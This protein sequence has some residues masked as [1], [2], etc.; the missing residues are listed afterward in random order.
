MTYKLPIYMQGT[1]SSSVKVVLSDYRI[2]RALASART[3]CPFP[4]YCPCISRVT[5]YR[6]RKS[7]RVTYWYPKVIR[8]TEKLIRLVRTR[9]D[10]KPTEYRLSEDRAG[11]IDYRILSFSL[12]WWQELLITQVRRTER[13]QTKMI[14][15][16]RCYKVCTGVYIRKA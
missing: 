13:G 9:P 4:K 1:S 16:L 14:F 7:G 11:D 10:K 5:N 12:G 8:I 2:R 3:L 6:I 15:E